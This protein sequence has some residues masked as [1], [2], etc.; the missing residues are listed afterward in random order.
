MSNDT[1]WIA[2]LAV[3]GLC[4]AY[5]LWGHPRTSDTDAVQPSNIAVAPDTKGDAPKPSTLPVTNPASSTPNDVSAKT[6]PTVSAPAPATNPAQTG[7]KLQDDSDKHGA[8][9]LLFHPDKIDF[10]TVPVN[11]SRQAVVKLENPSDKPITI[12]EL[13]GSCGC[14]K[15]TSTSTAV[16]PHGTLDVQVEFSAF[17]GRKTD[18]VRG[19]FKTNERS[20]PFCTFDITAKVREEFIVEPSPVDFETLVKGV[21]RTKDVLIRSVDGQPFKIKTVSGPRTE[22]SYVWEPAKD[23]KDSAYVIHVTLKGSVGGM[24]FDNAAIVTDRP[25][26]NIF[27]LHVA[28]MIAQDL[29]ANPAIINAEMDPSRNVTTFTTVIKRTTPG[30]L[31]ISS[32]ADGA[33]HPVA[34]DYVVDRIDD[35]SCRVSIKFKTPYPTRAP[36]GHFQIKTNVEDNDFNLPYRISAAGKGMP[37]PK[38][39]NGEKK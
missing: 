25:A 26:Q 1:R 19:Y 30:K 36:Y 33:Y 21:A 14:V 15:L 22:F 12:R 35:E 13:R 8:S 38:V 28:G 10:G 32:I 37:F 18:T 29:V 16:A 17:S 23:M 2:L 34:L 7:A 5:V 39:N 3:L 20:D 9:V 6:V 11:E 27:S 4:T 31:E 24:V